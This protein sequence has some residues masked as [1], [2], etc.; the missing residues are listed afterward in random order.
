MRTMRPS[1]GQILGVNPLSW[2]L[3]LLSPLQQE[4]ILYKYENNTYRIVRCKVEAVP[5]ILSH[6]VNDGIVISFLAR[7]ACR[8]VCLL[9]PPSWFAAA[10]SRA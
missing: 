10:F 1:Q 4:S 3:K 9:K 7:R 2:C 6:K 5:Q 8:P